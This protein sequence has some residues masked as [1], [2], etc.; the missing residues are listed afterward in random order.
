MIKNFVGYYVLGSKLNDEEEPKGLC[1]WLLKK[2]NSLHRFFMK[3]L[4]NVVWIDKQKDFKV[5][6]SDPYPNVKTLKLKTVKKNEQKSNTRR[7]SS[8]S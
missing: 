3:T 5:L 6:S 2:P 4:L 1:I 8:T 7:S